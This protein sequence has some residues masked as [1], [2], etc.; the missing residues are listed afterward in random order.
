MNFANYENEI[1]A[2]SYEGR[3]KLATVKKI[4]QKHLPTLKNNEIVKA[5]EASVR[6]L[7]KKN[8]LTYTKCN[9]DGYIFNITSTG[10][11]F[12]EQYFIKTGNENY[13]KTF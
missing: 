1:L 2:Y 5:T 9:K 11:N 12:I 3:I 13:I 7:I 4:I 6:S 10:E 8:S